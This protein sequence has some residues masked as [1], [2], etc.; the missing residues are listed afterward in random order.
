MA[1]VFLQDD[2]FALEGADVSLKGAYY[3][4]ST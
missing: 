1:N 2:P 3:L 4:F